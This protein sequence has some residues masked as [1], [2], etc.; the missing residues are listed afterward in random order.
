MKK[1]KN[2]LFL[3]GHPAHVHL[4]RNFFKSNMK[5]NYFVAALDK[6]ITLDLL[7][8]Y[9]I[10]FIRI[11][12]AKGT[13]KLARIWELIRVETVLFF[14]LIRK[15]IRIAV[16]TGGGLLFLPAK[17]LGI[18][19]IIVNEDDYK[20]VKIYARYSYPNAYRIIKPDALSYENFPNDIYH[21]SYHELAYL[22]PDNFEPDKSVLEKYCLKEK[23]YIIVRLSALKAHHDSNA[24]GISKE[25]YSKIKKLT[26]DYDIVESIEGSKT[27]RIEP[28][29]MHHVM[30][31]AKMLICDSQ[32]M[33][34]E[35]SVL[36]IPAVRINNIQ[37]EVISELGE[38]RYFLNFSFDPESS[39]NIYEKIGEIIHNPNLEEEWSAKKERML[40]EKTDLNKWLTNFLNNLD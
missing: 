34:M 38:K 12:R 28:W 39:Q 24:K 5:E 4:F 27:H 15:K 13:R 21:N 14:L 26:K 40:A 2:I 32:T 10:D 7:R 9:N 16:S 30:A 3:I 6:D 31:Y 25:L 19:N 29:D 20:A 22:H 8:H 23:K 18:K 37:A 17:I 1:N 35:A 33:T 11:K 36:G